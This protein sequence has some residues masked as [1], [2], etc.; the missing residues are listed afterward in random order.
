[1]SMLDLIVTCPY[2]KAHR[3][4]KSELFNHLTRCH[5]NHPSE[6]VQCPFEAHGITEKLY[7]KNHVLNHAS[8][9][10]DVEQYNFVLAPQ[11]GSVPL[12]TVKNL[13]VPI[14]KDWE[15]VFSY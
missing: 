13:S 14:M 8:S 12:E 7:F 10:N 6:K 3:I 4:H 15:E 5:K 11:L 1:M 9:G 2:D